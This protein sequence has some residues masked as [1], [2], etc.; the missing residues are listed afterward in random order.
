MVVRVENDVCVEVLSPGPLRG[1]FIYWPNSVRRDLPLQFAA[2]ERPFFLDRPW[3]G[4]DAPQ[5]TFN[6][7]RD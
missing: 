3:D 4:K 1:K 5:F 6:I 7:G 2:P